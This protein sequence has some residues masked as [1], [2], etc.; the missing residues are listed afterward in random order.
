MGENKKEEII[1]EKQIPR[2][3]TL[4]EKGDQVVED[5]RANPFFDGNDILDISV[6]KKLDLHRKEEREKLG[7]SREEAI[8]VKINRPQ[9][10]VG[11]RGLKILR[12]MKGIT[13]FDLTNILGFKWGI[14]SQLETGRKDPT[15]EQSDILC[16]YFSKSEIEVFGNTKDNPEVRDLGKNG[17]FLP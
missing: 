13:Q 7:L 6:N 1:I 2:N 16:K 15:K 12:I 10:L 5:Y 9:Q 17:Y 3:M 4:K 14:I 11:V 8:P